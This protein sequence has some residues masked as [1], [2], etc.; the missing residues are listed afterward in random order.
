MHI[1]YLQSFTLHTVF[2]RVLWAVFGEILQK[3]FDLDG[4]GGTGKTW[5]YNTL[6]S[7]L[8]GQGRSVCACAFT[9]IAG[10]LLTGGT[11]AHSTFGLPLNVFEN[12]VSNIKTDSSKRM[13]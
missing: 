8:R 9:G 3:L 12:S 2:E 1:T 6:I 11:T 10:N 4:P 7:Y 13:C 5:I